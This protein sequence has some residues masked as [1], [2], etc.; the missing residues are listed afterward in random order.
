MDHPHQASNRR[1]DRRGL[2]VGGATIFGGMWLLGRSGLA[3]AT[4]E[5]VEQAKDA[6]PKALLLLELSG[7]NDGLS[8]IVPWADDLYHG[9]RAR[10]GHKADTVKKIDD[11]RGFHFALANMQAQWNEGK[12]AIVEGCGYDDP[13]HS[14]FTSQ[15]IW[16]TARHT[17][18]ASGDGW[19]GR[20]MAEMHPQDKEV[21]HMVHVGQSLPYSLKSGSHAVVCLDQP[22]PYRWAAGG[23]DI[24]REGGMRRPEAGHPLE[25]IRSVVRNAQASSSAIRRAAAEY[26]PRV[27]YP[28]HDLGQDMQTAAALLQ[29]R[30]G[31]TVMS[32]TH[33]G[34]DTHA[35]QVYRHDKLMQELD[36]ALGAFL[37]DVRGTPSGDNI[38]ILVFSEFG[39]RVPDNA[40]MGTDHGTAGPMFLLGSPVKGGLHGKHPSLADLVDGDLKH[41]TDFRRVYASVLDGWFGVPNER[42]LG[43]RHEPIAG[44]WA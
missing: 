16:H 37:A 39:R 14:H 19:I 15:D 12:L 5:A 34:Y 27:E 22:P 2:L 44:V 40:S 6:P 21:P 42:V 26:K 17:G 11:Y 25:Q 3:R 1:P 43:A 23:D 8:C 35:N 13:N 30:L 20:L 29:S 9:A 36:G 41:T 32:V 10:T 18:R 33:H 38:A 24:A 7:G 31:V 4:R 28:K